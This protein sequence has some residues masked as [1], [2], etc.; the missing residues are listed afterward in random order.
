[1]ALK[2]TP[3]SVLVS[4]QLLCAMRPRKAFQ[5]HDGASVTSLDFD[6]TGQYLVSSGVD[7]SIQLYDCYKG[8]RVK[9]VQSQKYGAHAARFIRLDLSCLYALAPVVGGDEQDHT[10]RYLSLHTK[11]YL[12]YFKGHRDQVLDLAVSPVAD[13]FLLASA[14]HTV[15]LW[16]LRASNP[17]GSVGVGLVS[18]IAY[19]FQGMV[20]AVAQGPTPDQPGTVAFYDKAN[21]EKG[22]FLRKDV[23]SL[24]PERWTKAEFS[25]NGK[26]LLLSTDGPRH[27]VLDA[28]SGKLLARLVLPDQPAWPTFDYHS[29]GSLCFTP[30]G[31]FV[32][33]G[34][35][36]GE[37]ALFAL[38]ALKTEPRPGTDLLPCNMLPS[39]QGP[40]KIVAF[41]PKL[42]TMASAHS[43]VV[44]WATPDE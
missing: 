14:D 34:C 39:T 30:D 31:K 6:G 23:P 11:S 17:M 18:V 27:Y 10:V 37:V 25:N 24:A 3:H 12:R 33:A 29:L 9:E 41:D 2:K 19:D 7:K 26:Y 5:Y 36:S 20:F 32:V 44:L 8:T 22:P 28:F 16:D 42:F 13:A 4:E 15:K 38:S 43:S 21:F 35:P 1:M 40:A